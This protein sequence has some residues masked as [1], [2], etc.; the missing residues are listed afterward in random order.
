MPTAIFQALLETDLAACR[1]QSPQIFYGYEEEKNWNVRQRQI[2][3]AKAIC[4]ECV[5]RK[6]CL[7]YAQ[8][9]RDKFGIWGGLT[10]QERYLLRGNSIESTNY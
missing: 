3:I 10:E 6:E 4:A 2:V 7:D 5:I 1:D 9:K 8:S